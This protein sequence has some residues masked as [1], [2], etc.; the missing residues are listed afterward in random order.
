MYEKG[1]K[2]QEEKI[3]KTDVEEGKPVQLRTWQTLFKSPRC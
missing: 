2:Q 1:T 3:G